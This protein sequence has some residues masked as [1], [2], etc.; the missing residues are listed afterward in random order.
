VACQDELGFHSISVWDHFYSIAGIDGVGSFEAVS[1]H[2]ALA[3]STKHVRCGVFAYCAGYRHPAVLANAVATIDHLSGGRAEVGIGAGSVR[4]E[5]EAYGISFPPGG[6]LLD[7]LEESAHCLAGL[8][9]HEETDFAGDWFTLTAARC[10]PRP[11]Q[12]SVPIWVCGGGERRTIRLAAAVG[13][14][15]SLPLGNDPATF[16]RKRKI[17]LRHCDELGRDPAAVRCA[18]NVGIAPDESALRG[19]YG[20]MADEFRAGSLT[21]SLDEMT[22]KIARYVD[23]G[24]DHINLTVRP[25]YYLDSLEA[26]RT[27]LF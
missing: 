5:H 8:L 6:G 12:S 18:V 21:G 2:A 14:G 3:C 7:R 9:R 26:L 13:D 15:W 19:Q 16:G 25:P 17:L 27:E 1:M 22:D 11:V 23:A 4:F 20:D 24:A 10:D